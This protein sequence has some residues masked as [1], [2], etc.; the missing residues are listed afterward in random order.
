MAGLD[1]VGIDLKFKRARDLVDELDQ[2][3]HQFLRTDPPPYGVVE[4]ESPTGDLIWRA[5]VRAEPPAAWSLLAGDAIHNARSAL[6][7][8]AQVLVLRDMGEPDRH[9]AFPILDKPTGFSETA[10][11]VRR[12]TSSSTRSIVRDIQPWKGWGRPSVETA[13]ARHRGQA[14]PAA[15]IGRREHAHRHDDHAPAVA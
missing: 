6:D 4:E 8:L 13:P 5:E 15:R 12:G 7:H 14:P 11:K 10:R 1:R 9:T 2:S 3:A